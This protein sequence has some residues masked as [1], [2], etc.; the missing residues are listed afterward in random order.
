[1]VWEVGAL[2]CCVD[3]THTDM[4]RASSIPPCLSE[5]NNRQNGHRPPGMKNVKT[6]VRDAQHNPYRSVES[7]VQS[8]FRYG[9]S[10]HPW[11]NDP[12]RQNKRK[13][14]A[15]VRPSGNATPP[16]TNVARWS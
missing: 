11:P 9:L 4:E 13:I 7:I 16:R 6:S 3:S 2:S 1:M 10:T 5:G 8:C 14:V 12:D 15:M